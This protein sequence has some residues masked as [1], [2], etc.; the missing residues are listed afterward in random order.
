M[1]Q[2]LI[3]EAICDHTLKNLYGFLAYDMAY[4]TDVQHLLNELIAS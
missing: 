1:I 3:T 4:N 2:F